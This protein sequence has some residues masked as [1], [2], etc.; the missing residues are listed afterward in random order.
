MDIDHFKNYND[1]NGHLAG[2]ELLRQ[3]AALISNEVRSE[4][5]FGRFGGEE[6]LLILPDRNAKL[7]ILAAENIRR[8]IANHSFPYSNSQPLGKLSISGGVAELTSDT[9]SSEEILKAADD[10]LYKAKLASRNR[11]V[12]ADE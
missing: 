6:F 5:I 12:C 3:L 8:R 2:D 10:A 4:D 7:G 11:V 1:T 9:K